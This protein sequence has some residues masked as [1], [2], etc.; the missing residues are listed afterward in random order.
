M[1]LLLFR[2][3]LILIAVA[4]LVHLLRKLASEKRLSVEDTL[5]ALALVVTVYFALFPFMQQSQIE[6]TRISPL[7]DTPTV[8]PL[9]LDLRVWCESGCV[10]SPPDWQLRLKPIADFSSIDSDSQRLLLWFVEQGRVPSL[11]GRLASVTVDVRGLRQDRHLDD[12]APIG[13]VIPAYLPCA[14]PDDFNGVV[15]M[16]ISNQGGSE[17]IRVEKEP[18]KDLVS[19]YRLDET[20]H[21]FDFMGDQGGGDIY[22]YKMDVSPRDFNGGR[23]R[24]LTTNELQPGHTE[25]PAYFA[26]EP[27][28]SDWLSIRVDCTTPGI[29]TY[30][31]GVEYI[32]RGKQDTLWSDHYVRVVV[33]RSYYRW[34]VS[35]F[36]TM[37]LTGAYHWNTEEA[38]WIEVD[39]PSVD[40]WME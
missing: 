3:V 35:W 11:D 22:G 18:L 8:E 33:P 10:V 25:A 20:V 28:E 34:F 39:S 15:D 24:P 14:V 23:I 5:A 30:R 26:L 38:R 7:V 13:T 36:D 21:W 32:Y 2:V 6:P 16:S 12:N 37:L 27:G 1:W 19:Y 9:R 29:Y 40:P 31:L 4:L 17:E